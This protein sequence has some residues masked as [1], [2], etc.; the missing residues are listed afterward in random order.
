MTTEFKYD[1]ISYKK[2]RA[3][4]IYYTDCVITHNNIT[5][6]F[7][8]NDDWF[9]DEEDL[10]EPV[11]DM[12]DGP[13]LCKVNFNH[14]DEVF[15]KCWEHC[16]SIPGMPSFNDDWWFYNDSKN[17]IMRAYRYPLKTIEQLIIIQ[18]FVWKRLQIKKRKHTMSY[19][20]LTQKLNKYVTHDVSKYLDF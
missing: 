10:F 13:C 4:D 17:K 16:V 5:T 8:Y 18:N 11:H 12:N 1:T 6:T 15:Y 2:G 19:V 20:L 14:I 7:M 3:R 9:E